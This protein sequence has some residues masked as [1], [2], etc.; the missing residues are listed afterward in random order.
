MIRI[1]CSTT[2]EAD[3]AWRL[4]AAGDIGQEVE[5][6][7]DGDGLQATLWRENASRRLCFRRAAAG[8]ASA[9]NTAHTGHNPV[10]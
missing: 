2:E 7:L 9:L 5:L 8:S 6:H 10:R 4:L 3:A 1:H